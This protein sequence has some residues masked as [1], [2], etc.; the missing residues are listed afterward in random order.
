MALVNPDGGVAS[1][2]P[3]KATRL[4]MQQIRSPAGFA[5]N[6]AGAVR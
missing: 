3:E 4:K 5:R 6:F 1:A 2:I